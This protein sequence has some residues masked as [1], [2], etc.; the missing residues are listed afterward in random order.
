MKGSV[1]RRLSSVVLSLLLL[2]PAASRQAH[3]QAPFNTDFSAWDLPL[4]AGQW[5]ISRGPCASESGFDHQ[6]G[7]YE[8]ECALDLTSSLGSMENVPVLAPQDGQVFF[9]GT[10]AD[11][12]LALML[13]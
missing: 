3:A 1:V 11:S 2:A 6:C 7:Y 13:Q 4:P 5:T 8:D 9:I 10:R 12:G